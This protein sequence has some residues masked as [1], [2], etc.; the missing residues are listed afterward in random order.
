MPNVIKRKQ[1]KGGSRKGKPNKLTKSAK[2][3]FLFAFDELGGSKGLA[4]WAKNNQTDFYKL[5]S[6]I[7]PVDV[8][9]NGNTI[10]FEI[11]IGQDGKDSNTDT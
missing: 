10:G 3:A 2:E 11:V 1:P 4:S 7:I 5:F 8:V 9:S 6:K